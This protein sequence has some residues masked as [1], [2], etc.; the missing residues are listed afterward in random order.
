MVTRLQTK[1]QVAGVVQGL[2][3]LVDDQ[4]RCQAAVEVAGGHHHHVGTGD[5]LQ[6]GR[7][8]QRVGFEPDPWLGGQR[9]LLAD[10]ELAPYR[11]AVGPFGTEGDVAEGGRVDTAVDVEHLAGQFDGIGKA[12]GHLFQRGQEQ[13]A[14]GMPFQAALVETVVEQV[15]HL[16]T[17]AE[18]DQALAHVARWQHAQLVTQGAGGSAIIGHVDQCADVAHVLLESAQQGEAAGAAADD[19]DLGARDFVCGHVVSPCQ[20]KPRRRGRQGSVEGR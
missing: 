19:D 9:R 20:K 14:K 1:T 5:G 17:L 16:G 2:T 6:R 4:H 8:G 7:I 15:A 11:L 3:D 10:G 18:C 13:V 12:A